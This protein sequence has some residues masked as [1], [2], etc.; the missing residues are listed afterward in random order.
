MA[1]GIWTQADVRNPDTR[2]GIYVNIVTEARRQLTPGTG[3][4][5]VA[6]VADWG[7]L[8]SVVEI[9]S[10]DDLYD[11]FDRAGSLPV[12]AAQALRGGAASVSCL[13]IAGSSAAAATVTLVDTDPSPAAVLDLTARQQGARANDFAITTRAVA[14]GLGIEIAESGA[15]I[16]TLVATDTDVDVVVTA[17]NTY[18]AY[19]T[20]ARNGAPGRDVAAQTVTMTGGDSGATL[21]AADYTAAQGIAQSAEFDCYVQGDDTTA[22]NQDA[23]S[24]WADTQRDEGNRFVAVMGGPS[25]ETAAQAGV[26]AVALDSM[27]TVYV[28]P[29]VVDTDGTTYT[30]QQ[31]AG[32]VAGMIANA[33]FARAVTWEPIPDADRPNTVLSNTEVTTA[34]GQ[35]VLLILSDRSGVRLSRGLNTLNSAGGT[36]QPSAQFQKIRTVATNDAISEGL[37][38]GITPYIGTVTNDEDGRRS[39][40]AAALAYL[41]QLVAGG[42]IE[43]GPTVE[44][45]RGTAD[46]VFLRVQVTVLDSIEEVFITV[47]IGE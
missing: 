4:V 9:A 37:E 7:V 46:Q 35:G 30:G 16:E 24:D 36:G 47:R 43:E 5:L 17:I 27:S 41:E 38:A 39:V 42:A 29:G 44:V 11:A 33:G 13:R 8:D 32:R 12:V 6:G 21:T 45:S 28:F 1:G 10:E 25:G 2:P 22:A 19:L 15:L 20:A 14:G 40:A 23:V 26:R 18:S 31:A 34:L 3:V